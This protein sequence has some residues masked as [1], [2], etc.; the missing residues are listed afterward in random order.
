MDDITITN[1]P[2]VTP[3]AVTRTERRRRAKAKKEVQA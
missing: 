3:P 2:F 1:P